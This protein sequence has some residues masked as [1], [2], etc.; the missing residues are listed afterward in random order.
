[1]LMICF[2]GRH[3]TEPG[4][5]HSTR[6][7]LFEELSTT[8]ESPASGNPHILHNS[9]A[10][11]SSEPPQ[12][13]NP[14]LPLNLRLDSSLIL[15][16]LRLRYRSATNRLLDSRLSVLAQIHHIQSQELG[17][18]SNC[19]EAIGASVSNVLEPSRSLSALRY[20][21]SKGT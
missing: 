3:C 5:R 17:I 18:D 16:Y 13:K 4:R 10:L 1:M 8:C 6:S 2:T 21:T 12:Q 11:P 9:E 20:P 15:H 19:T 14:S 7:V